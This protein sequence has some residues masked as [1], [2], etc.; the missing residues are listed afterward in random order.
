MQLVAACSSLLK[1]RRYL[2]GGTGPGRAF[3][4]LG[5]VL[6]FIS[7]RMP[8][9]GR[10]PYL[11][12]R[13]GQRLPTGLSGATRERLLSQMWK[14]MSKDEKDLWRQDQPQLG[15]S[16]ANGA[17]SVLSKRPA[18]APA[19]APLAKQSN[20]SPFSR[21]CWEQ[22]RFLPMNLSKAE[23]DR[24]LVLHWGAL[25]ETNRATY[26]FGGSRNP[27]QARPLVYTCLQSATCSTARDTFALA[28]APTAAP[29][30]PP[31]PFPAPAAAPSVPAVGPTPTA[32]PTPSVPL[33]PTHVACTG[34]E[35]ALE[36]ALELLADTPMEEQAILPL[37]HIMSAEALPLDEALETLLTDC[38]SA[39]MVG[40]VSQVKAPPAEQ[41][42]NDLAP[43]PL[44]QPTTPPMTPPPMRPVPSSRALGE[45]VAAAFAPTLLTDAM[46]EHS[47]PTDIE[48]TWQTAQQESVA[49]DWNASTPLPAD[50]AAMFV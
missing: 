40:A 30:V 4:S 21:F 45:M 22:V 8:Y 18:S 42:F 32:P 35:E 47:L 28:A 3:A 31:A 9:P 34:L 24:C 11:E 36:V 25:S 12:F 33:S 20:A 43:H 39:E 46:A 37:P 50:I 38:P 2:S 15:A 7:N 1:G 17:Y 16:G 27:V 29:P 48:G 19:P 14:A 44:Q 13:K 23:I 41:T 49:S 5:V 10:N 6:L 26:N